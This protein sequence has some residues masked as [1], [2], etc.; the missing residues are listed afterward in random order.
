M[1]FPPD[2]FEILDKILEMYD[3]DKESVEIYLDQVIEYLVE[4]GVL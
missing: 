4:N 3:I 1:F 2:F